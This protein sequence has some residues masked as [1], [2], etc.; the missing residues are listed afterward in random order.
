MVSIKARKKGV[1][2]RSKSD[3]FK[4]PVRINGECFEHHPSGRRFQFLSSYYCVYLEDLPL[5]EYEVEIKGNKMK[6][7]GFKWKEVSDEVYGDLDHD[8]TLPSRFKA[9]VYNEGYRPDN[10][11][12]WGILKKWWHGTPSM[13]REDK[14]KALGEGINALSRKLNAG[15]NS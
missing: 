10:P 2:V 14:S 15:D 5:G 12:T 9:K 11:S 8:G 1:V 7:F 6:L 4:K 3:F 13:S